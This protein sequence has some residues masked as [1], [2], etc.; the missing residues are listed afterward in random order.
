MVDAT[1]AATFVVGI[2]IAVDVEA[3]DGLAMGSL[4]LE[5]VPLRAASIEKGSPPL[6]FP[7]RAEGGSTRLYGE[8][9][10]RFLESRPIRLCFGDR[11]AGADEVPD[12][13]MKAL[14]VDE[15]LVK[16][17]EVGVVALFVDG[18]LNTFS[19][20]EMFKLKRGW[21]LFEGV[22]SKPFERFEEKSSAGSIFSESKSSSLWSS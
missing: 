22:P 4:A 2:G 19:L 21:F 7:D 13:N 12:G 15:D 1:E 20:G 18:V 16:I 17:G 9:E 5:R 8:R 14:G 10:F 11:P 6:D 3:G